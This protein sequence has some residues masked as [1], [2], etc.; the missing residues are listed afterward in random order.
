MYILMTSAA[1][2]TARVG[3]RV[4]NF[5]LYALFAVVIAFGGLKITF[6]VEDTWGHDAFI[7]WGGLAAFTLGLFALFV[8]DSE[9][10]L[11]KWRFW[12]VTAI[13]LA[14]HLAAFA[15]VLTYVQEWKLMWF[16]VMVV[17][18]PLFLLIR[19]RFVS[20]EPR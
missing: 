3:N 19:G 6:T 9:K 20:P 5:L 10:L 14:V 12:V 2:G 8:G 13:L 18:Y 11:R 1:Q 4:R 15:I 16:M 17:E 7:R